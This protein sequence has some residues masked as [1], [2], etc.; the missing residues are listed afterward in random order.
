MKK[1]K[2]ALASP[3]RPNHL[4][5]WGVTESGEEFRPND[6]AERMSGKLSTLRNHRLLYSPLLQPITQKG[7]KCLLVDQGLETSNPELYRSIL[8]FIH[9]NKLKVSKDLFNNSQPTL[10]QTE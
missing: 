7:H 9:D 6:W 1:N 2:I 5:I 3:P 8:E 4:I 10:E